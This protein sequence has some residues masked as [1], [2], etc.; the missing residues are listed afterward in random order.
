MSTANFN[1]YISDSMLQSK[2]IEEISE[3]IESK[4]NGP[5]PKGDPKID[6]KFMSN[7]KYPSNLK[8]ITNKDN[9]SIH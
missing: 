3:L 8:Y 2:T 4:K 6:L 1:Q 5:M 7:L 9:K